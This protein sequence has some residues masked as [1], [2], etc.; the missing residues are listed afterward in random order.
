MALR[1]AAVAFETVPEAASSGKGAA[2]TK[3]TAMARRRKNF[4]IAKDMFVVGQR[5]TDR[6]SLTAPCL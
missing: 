5:K 3:A 4:R 6:D 2:S 1:T